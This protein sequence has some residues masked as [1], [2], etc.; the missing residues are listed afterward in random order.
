MCCFCSASNSDRLRKN[1]EFGTGIWTGAN[2]L[3]YHET[4]ISFHVFFVSGDF[5]AELDQTRSPAG[6][7]F[8]KKGVLYSAFPPQLIVDVEADIFRC[9]G[10]LSEIVSPDYGTSLMTDAS[11][12][13][14]WKKGEEKKVVDILSIT[15]RHTR[16]LRWDY[17][18]KI[19]S[20]NV[21]LTNSL[22][23]DVSLRDGVSSITITAGLVR[24]NN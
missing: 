23:I 11:F 9:S 17:Y 21:P 24:D 7:E 15:K 6:T 18:I 13:I 8:R 19:P 14:A 4:C 2:I 5:F 1:T 20:E 16:G 12:E 3:K 22:A 10:N